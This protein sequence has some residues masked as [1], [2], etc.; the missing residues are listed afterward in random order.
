MDFHFPNGCVRGYE[1]IVPTLSL[2]DQKDR[3]VFAV[4][5]QT[6]S[7]WIVT[8]NLKDFPKAILHPYE[9][10]AVSPDEFVQRLIQQAP[11]PILWSVKNH[12]LGLTRPPRAFQ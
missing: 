8:F 10:E 3:Y 2:P 5:I 7:S 1:S 6:R 12:R 9:I 11:E 4:A